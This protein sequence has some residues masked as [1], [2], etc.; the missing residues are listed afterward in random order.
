MSPYTQ[1]KAGFPKGYTFPDHSPLKVI[2]APAQQRSRES[3][4]NLLPF[5]AVPFM[6]STYSFSLYPPH[7]SLLGTPSQSCPFILRR[8]WLTINLPIK[9]HSCHNPR[10]QCLNSLMSLIPMAS[11]IPSISTIYFIGL[12]VDPILANSSVLAHHTVTLI[13]WS[14]ISQ[15]YLL[16]QLLYFLPTC[17]SILNSPPAYPGY[18][19]G[20]IIQTILSPSHSIHLHLSTSAVSTS[21]ILTLQ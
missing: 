5:S 1:V 14:L 17:Q 4:S 21:K 16:P 13:C 7:C 18:N 15:R 12:H 6:W 11:C 10:I 19:P 8:L 9:C 3:V 2:N 20:L